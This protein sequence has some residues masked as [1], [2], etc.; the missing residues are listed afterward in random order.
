MSRP[1]RHSREK[2]A[3][4]SGRG[5]RGVNI[6]LI[7]PAEART[8]IAAAP[9]F[10]TPPCIG[11]TDTYIAGLCENVNYGTRVFMR[12]TQAR[13][14]VPNSPANSPA[15]RENSAAGRCQHIVRKPL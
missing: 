5:W 8:H 14:D 9:E 11:R 4:K 2:R 13:G 15:D 7:V 6:L 12:N 3:K 10:S 1:H